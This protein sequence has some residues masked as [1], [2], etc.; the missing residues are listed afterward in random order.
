MAGDW[1]KMRAG[2]RTSLPVFEMAERTG[3]T[4][5]EVVVLLYRLAEWFSAHGDYGVMRQ[6]P[7]IIDL[8]LE[9]HGFSDLL[10]K[11][12]WM[13]SECG[14]LILRHFTNVSSVRKSIGKKLRRQILASAKCAH[15]GSDSQLEID[16]ISPVSRGGRTEPSNLQ[17]LCRPCNAK[18]GARHDY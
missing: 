10:I 4:P 1:I 12:D 2:L 13:R 11:H 14:G 8:F 15:C 7:K 18:K 9:T 16:H 17:A 3:K 5:D 6:S